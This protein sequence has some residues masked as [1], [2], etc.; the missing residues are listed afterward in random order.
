M[1][2]LTFCGNCDETLSEQA[3][4]PVEKRQPCPKCGSTRRNFG[5]EVVSA[6][7]TASCSSA[8]ATVTKYPKA[9][10]TIAQSLIDQKHFNIAIITSHM[11]CEI[12]AER[13]FDAAYAAK[14]LKSLGEAIDGLMNGHNLANE[15]HRK[16]YNALTGTELE[17]QSFWHRFKNA[18]EK[19]NSIIH[20]SGQ[21]NKNEAE[22]ALKVATE[23]IMHLKQM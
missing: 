6:S 15:K 3:S 17:K 14:E 8:T 5:A 9:L 20:K 10:M 23:L 12:A 7:F 16:L 4:T 2:E 11:A 13:A 19:R 1:T 22:A 18:S 21:A